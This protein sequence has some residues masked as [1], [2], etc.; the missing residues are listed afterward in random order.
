MKRLI[1]IF[2]LLVCA[3][4]AIAQTSFLSVAKWQNI[5]L[6]VCQGSGASLAGNII[7]ATSPI[8]TCIS[9]SANVPQHGGSAFSTAGGVGTGTAQEFQLKVPDNY[10]ANHAFIIEYDWYDPT[11]NNADHT[12]M[13]GAQYVSVT[14]P[15]LSAPTFNAPSIATPTPINGTAGSTTTVQQTFYPSVG[16]AAVTAGDDFYLRIFLSAKTATD[17]PVL[18][19]LRVKWL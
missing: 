8:A 1:L 4:C 10:T 12:V 11:D 7:V 16:N 9:G 6:A 14:P 5:S 2:A 17:S 13:W 18:I 19:G 3:P 15:G